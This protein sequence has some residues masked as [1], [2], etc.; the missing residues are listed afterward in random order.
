MVQRPPRWPRRAQA[1]RLAR[2]RARAAARGD[3]SSRR[4][5]CSPA[6]NR[7]PSLP[8]PP[9][10]PPPPHHPPRPHSAPHSAPHSHR[11]QATSDRRPR[12]LPRCSARRRSAHRTCRAPS[13]RQVG[14]PGRLCSWAGA[15]RAARAATRHAASARPAR[16]TPPAKAA[17][18]PTTPVW[19]PGP[20]RAAHRP[21]PPALLDR[22]SATRA[23]APPLKA[24]RQG[25]R[26]PD[27]RSHRVC[28]RPMRVDGRCRRS[29]RSQRERR[30]PIR[31]PPLRRAAVSTRQ[32]AAGTSWKQPAGRVR[33]QLRP[34]RAVLRKQTHAEALRG[35]GPPWPEPPPS[36]GRRRQRPARGADEWPRRGAEQRPGLAP[37]HHKNV[38]S[39]A[40]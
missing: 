8:R 38:A 6:R 1:A 34:T 32:K 22:K 23:A 4:R 28:C 27:R 36:C 26:P 31:R 3:R 24:S 35:M 9:R 17:E 11:A 33:P 2:G 12:R 25:V 30:S 10:P 40:G 21:A 15:P 29:R 19:P 14:L 18:P 39:R 16:A 7:A 20:R 13:T 5:A 37:L